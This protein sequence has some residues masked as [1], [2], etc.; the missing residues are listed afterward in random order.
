MKKFNIAFV[1]LSLFVLS[2]TAYAQN[3]TQSPAS[4]LIPPPAINLPF[5]GKLM[6]EICLNDSDFLGLIKQFVPMVLE[7]GKE[8]SGKSGVAQL[9]SLSPII[10]D[11]DFTPLSEAIEGVKTVRIVTAKYDRSIS[12]EK[13]ISEF[14]AGLVKT[15]KFNKIMSD[16]SNK[17]EVK[18][19]YAQADNGGYVAFMYT[20][21]TKTVNAGRLVGYLDIQKIMLW[22][23]EISKKIIPANMGNPN[24]VTTPGTDAP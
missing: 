24:I 9:D 20:P 12:G 5:G 23:M 8:Y 19:I 18:G 13:F 7:M 6:T 17:A 10:K 15:G 22:G 14:E 2:A 3:K 11:L 1:C 4:G 16:S 21:G